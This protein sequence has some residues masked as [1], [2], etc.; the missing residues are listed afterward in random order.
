MPIKIQVVVAEETTVELEFDGDP[1]SADQVEAAIDKA[2]K[3]T[4]DETLSLGKKIGDSEK[5]AEFWKVNRDYL[6]GK[7]KPVN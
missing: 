3:M 5:F 2:N 4:P 6:Q 1:E 7:D